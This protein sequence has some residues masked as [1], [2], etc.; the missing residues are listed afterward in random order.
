MYCSPCQSCR[1]ALPAARATLHLLQA[2]RLR[3]GVGAPG[4]WWPTALPQ[5]KHF[6]TFL[7]QEALTSASQMGRRAVGCRTAFLLPLRHEN[8]TQS[9]R[10]LF[11]SEGGC[12]TGEATAPVPQLEIN[13][14][15]D[16][17]PR[18]LAA[19]TSDFLFLE[20]GR[21]A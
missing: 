17:E 7:R 13:P 6:P 8:R 3:P 4:C 20:L 9:L 2:H 1:H 12:R 5:E 11:P 19:G 21:G 16:K 14:H 18:A 10:S 15:S